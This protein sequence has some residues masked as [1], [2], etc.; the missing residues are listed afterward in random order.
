[1]SISRSVPDAIFLFVTLIPSGRWDRLSFT[2]P[3]WRLYSRSKD[4]RYEGPCEAL[5]LVRVS[6][7][8]WEE[9]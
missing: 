8:R 2:C 6:F 9:D 7:W 3:D 1:M 4:S 5:G